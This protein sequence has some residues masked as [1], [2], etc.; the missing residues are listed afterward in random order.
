MLIREGVRSF[1][2]HMTKYINGD[3]VVI[4]E[5]SKTHNEKGVFMPYNLYFLFQAQIKEAIREDIKNS[6]TEDFDGVGV[7]HED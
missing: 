3:R 4:I 5:D 1:Q 2:K 6:F 7:V